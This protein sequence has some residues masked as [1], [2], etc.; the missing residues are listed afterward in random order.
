MDRDTGVQVG[1]AIVVG[2]V[3]FLVSA[4]V[5]SMVTMW[6]FKKFGGCPMDPSK[7]KQ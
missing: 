2:I 3:I 1:E 7:K 5:E 4:I 6:M